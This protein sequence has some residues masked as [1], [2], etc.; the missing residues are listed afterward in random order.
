MKN[1]YSIAGLMSILLLISGLL[2]AYASAAETVVVTKTYELTEAADY[3]EFTL[4]GYDGAFTSTMT[5]PNGRVAKMTKSTK[6]EDKE[7]PFWVNAYSVESAPKGTYTFK[8]NAPK[9]AYYNLRVNIP[10]FKDIPNHWA[11]AAINA[12]V[13]K[14]IVAGY[15]D[16]RF[17]PDDSVTGEA[18]VKM[19]VL[20]LTEDMPNGKRQWTKAFRWKVKDEAVSKEMGFQEFVF[21]AQ[22]GEPWS[23]PYLAAAATI[24]MT[25]NWQDKQLAG[26]F[27]RKDVALLL[28]NVITMVQPAD[29]KASTYQDTKNLPEN[30]RKAIDLVSSFS[31]FSGYPDGSFKPEST[32]TRAEAVAVLSRL[33]DFMK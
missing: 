11:Q 2:P 6:I 1:K 3:I 32:V 22:K 13:E 8:I 19:A 5:M 16:G 14:G 7:K 25:A 20:T 33:N 29:P 27:K 24:K 12:F 31:I 26:P 9:A 4:D 28:A 18:L 10:L 17:G 21:T 23:K 30:Y 15:G